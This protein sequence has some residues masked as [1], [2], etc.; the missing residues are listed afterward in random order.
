MKHGGRRGSMGVVRREGNV[1][2]GAV[3]IFRGVS[4]PRC[5][6]FFAE[7]RKRRIRVFKVR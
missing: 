5:G 1:K 6:S 4:G 2:H 3:L 7:L